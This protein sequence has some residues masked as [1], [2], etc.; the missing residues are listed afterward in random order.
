MTDAV[1]E[2]LRLTS[3]VQGLARTITRDVRVADTTIPAGRKVLLLYGSA[4]RDERE[5]GA[6]AG[7]LEVT[8]APAQHHDVQPRRALLPRRGRGAD[9]VAH[10]ADR[11]PCP[12]PG[13]RGRRV[14]RRLGRRKLRAQTA[15]GS[16][17]VTG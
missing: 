6:D 8:Q 12:L 9:A 11:T 3:P 4:N 16:V 15:F 10:R 17:P 1:D 13:F 7:E 2:L 14:R 5:Y